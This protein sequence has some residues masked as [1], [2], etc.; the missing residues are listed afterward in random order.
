MTAILD[1]LADDGF[2][3]MLFD[4]DGTITHS[5]EAA[6]R[7][8][9]RWAK[10]QGLDVDAFLPTIHGVRTVDTIARLNLPGVDPAT[11]AAKITATE[12][13]D[14]EGVKEIPGAIALLRALPSDRWAVVTSAPR[15][16][17]ESRMQAAGLPSPPLL[18]SA[19][20]VRVGKPAPE[21]YL[22]AARKL[23]VDIAQ[24]LIFEDADAGIQAAEASG[25]QLIVVTSTHNR[26]AGSAPLVSPPQV[27]KPYIAI[28]DFR[29]TKASLLRK[30]GL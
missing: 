30:L 12:I 26:Q 3:A 11:E 21:G 2:K 10:A 28:E 6:E 5:I 17:A 1:T 15:A 25:G 27:S 24:C 14:T 13:N 16:L 19:E 8:W 18:I 22:A 20:D 7:I 29:E 23:G 4:M 9:A